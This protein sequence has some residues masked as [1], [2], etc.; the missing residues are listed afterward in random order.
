MATKTYHSKV[1]W[2]GEKVRSIAEA[3]GKKY[4]IDE[5]KDLGGTDLGPNPVE[6]ILGA[7]GGCINVLVVTFAKKF[8]VEVKDLYVEIE[9]D[10]D[11]DGFLGKNTTVRPGYEEI[12]YKVHLESPSKLENI[13]ALLSHVDRVCPV[14]DTLQ[15][16]ILKNKTKSIVIS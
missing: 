4:I 5:P 14:K 11:S 9:G 10:L 8:D 12:R 7:L 1:T 6:Y 2:T 15:G 3:K 16:T 13:K